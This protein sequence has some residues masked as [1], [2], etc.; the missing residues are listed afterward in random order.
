LNEELREPSRAKK[1]ADVVRKSTR[2]RDLLEFSRSV[3]A[4]MDAIVSIARRGGP[5][6]TGGSLYTTTFPCHN[7][8]RHIVAAG[9]SK[10]FYIEPYEKSLALSLHSDSIASD[11][12]ETDGSKVQFL[13]F[14]GVAPRQYQELFS[15]KDERKKGGKA[16]STKLAQAAKVRVQYLD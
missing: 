11:A 14:E 7:C 10:V 15:M 12:E 13:H 16:I 5:S 9:I 4:E 1:L 8:A 6:V 2:L 3:H